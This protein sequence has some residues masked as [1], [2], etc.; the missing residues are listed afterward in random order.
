MVLHSS[1]PS[2]YFPEDVRNISRK[3]C[4]KVLG[5]ETER[6]GGPGVVGEGCGAAV[7]SRAP[8]EGP[9]KEGG[10]TRGR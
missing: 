10:G 8:R 9:A 2:P 6:E 5:R 4:L 1:F 3:R 7:L